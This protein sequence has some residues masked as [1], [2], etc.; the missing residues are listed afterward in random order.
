MIEFASMQNAAEKLEFE[1]IKQFV[2]NFI[3]TEIGKNTVLNMNDFLSYESLVNE[4]NLMKEMIYAHERFGTLPIETSSD[5]E[6][7]FSFASKGGVLSERELEEVAHDITINLNIQKYFKQFEDDNEL[8][9]IALQTEDMS[10]FEEKIHSVIAPD[11]SIFDNASP[12]LKTIR[13][14]IRKL[15]RDITKKVQ[16]LT[17]EHGEYLTS[18]SLT[19]RDGHYVLPVS[20][21]YKTKVKGII[22]DISHSG[23]TTFI[24]PEALVNMN[25]K[26]KELLSEEREEIHRILESLSREIGRKHNELSLINQTIGRLDFIEAKVRYG[27]SMNGVICEFSKEP[28]VLLKEARHPLIDPKKVVPNDFTIKSDTPIYV[29]SGPNAGGKTIALKTVGLLVY[30]NECGLPIPADESSTLGYFEHVYVD[31]GDSQSIADSLSTFSGHMANLSELLNEVG[32]NDL[33]LLD[34]VGTGTSPKEG[35]SLAYA[36]LMDLK[37]KKAFALVSSH[38]DGL[39]AAAM[40]EEGIMNASMR[41]D[42]E[43]LSPTYRLIEG[44][45]GDSYGLIVARRFGMN[46]EVMRLAEQKASETSDLSV[47]EALRKLN[48]ASAALEKERIEL[49]KQKNAIELE[50]KQLDENNEKLERRLRSLTDEINKAKEKELKE[51]KEKADAIL[52]NLQGNGI[53]KGDVTKAKTKLDELIAQ[54]EEIKFNEPLKEGNYVSLPSLG[55]E[56]RIKS[57]NGNNVYLVSREGLTFQTKKDRLTRI[58]E[59]KEKIESISGLKVDESGLGASVPLELNLIGMRAEPAL[60]ALDQYLDKCRIKKYKRVRIIHGFGSGVLRK[61]VR[62]YLDKHKEFVDHYEGAT[63]TEGAGGA[64]IV[65]LK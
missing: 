40:S 38:F 11:L 39:K 63:E 25:N 14:A 18:G 47:T 60:S 36:I 1:R 26:M 61:I 54:P 53:K 55:V 5:L 6:G 16:S 4:K 22:M 52:E 13:N 59:P 2:L 58:P 28:C 45:P 57:I 3:K 43:T 19:L 51:F 17:S 34:E 20:T 48:D 24:E 29:I 35:E 10:Y 50:K 32:S 41:F 46:E 49:I 12:N 44:I 9:K 65:Y 64:T 62:E 7:I 42:E 8:K 21:S 33:V 30:M 37:K 27:E 23:G 56:G 15:T 31:I